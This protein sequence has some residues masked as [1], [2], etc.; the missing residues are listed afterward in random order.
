MPYADVFISYS[1]KDNKWKDHVLTFMKV[2]QE[3]GQFNY[4]A[5]HDKKIDLGKNWENEIDTALNQAKV[6]LLLISPDF[7]QSNF[8]LKYEVPKLKKRSND[9]ELVMIPLIIRPC[10]W[11]VFDWLK[12][13]QGY[14][15]DDVILSGCDV[16]GIELTLTKLVREIDRIIA[17]SKS[18]SEEE[19]E[20]IVGSEKVEKTVEIGEVEPT[21]YYTSRKDAP[22]KTSD[23]FLTNA[24]V[25]DLINNSAPDENIVGLI[26]IFKTRKQRTWLVVTSARLFCVL[27]SERTASAGRRMQWKLS[28]GEA[29]PVK[30]RER[31]KK[32]TGLVD[33]GRKRNWLYSMRLH[34]NSEALKEKIES[35][36]EKGKRS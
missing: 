3:A 10:P 30:V 26:P 22:L 13:I 6:A 16:H 34:P 1:H 2:M 35:M 33:I 14:L 19:E 12:P 27:D 7:L 21:G 32:F 31:S 5:W 15:E 29:D 18:A 36:I 20:A 28:L 17:D 23:G 25:T 4:E 11:E 24:G 9:G 8:I